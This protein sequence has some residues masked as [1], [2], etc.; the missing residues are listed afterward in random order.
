MARK[1]YVVELTDEER[2]ELSDLISA[3]EER[4]RKLTRARILLKTDEGWTDERISA[5]ANASLRMGLWRSTA[6]SP[7]VPTNANSMEPPKHASLP[8]H[9]ASHP[10]VTLGGH[11]GSSLRN[12]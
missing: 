10:W 9:V 11:C 12:S 1:K 8:W 4:A 3:G 6:A 2:T 5:H 7:T